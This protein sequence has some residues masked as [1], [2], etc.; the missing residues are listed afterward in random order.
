MVWCT[1]INNKWLFELR[2]I[3]K[4]LKLIKEDYSDKN[5]L[6]HKYPSD[7]VLKGTYS[8]WLSEIKLLST[9]N[10]DGWKK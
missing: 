10:F 3:N 5:K 6:C 7:E 9:T 1:L 8:Q 4:I 2:E